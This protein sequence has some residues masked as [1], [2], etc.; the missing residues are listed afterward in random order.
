VGFG[1]FHGV[2]NFGYNF[3]RSLPFVVIEDVGCH[4]HL[5]S[6]GSLDHMLQ[7]LPDGV[8]TAD[9][10]ASERVR[11]DGPGIG[12]EARLKSV[13]GG[14]TWLGLPV[15]LLRV[16]CCNDENRKAASQSDSAAT[17]VSP[18]IRYGVASCAEGQKRS[19]Y[20]AIACIIIA[21]AKCEAMLRKNL[22]MTTPLRGWTC[23][24]RHDR[25]GCS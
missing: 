11:Q 7:T 1:L 23:I 10:S 14:G 15:R 4:H 20:I 22:R 9:D 16:D 2:V 5:I 8:G 19:R 24:R 21:G 13:M 17:I 3:E 6:A 12:I 25:D 18:S